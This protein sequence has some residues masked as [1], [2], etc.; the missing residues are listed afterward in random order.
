MGSGLDE[1]V[2]QMYRTASLVAT[3]Q[4]RTKSHSAMLIGIAGS[5]FLVVAV[6]A[7]VDLLLFLLL[8]LLLLLL[9]P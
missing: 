6:V 3:S 9:L 8:L 7:V 5:S 2:A 1:K 4:C